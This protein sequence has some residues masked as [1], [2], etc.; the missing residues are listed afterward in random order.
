MGKEG[1][2]NTDSMIT[3]K[4]SRID[5]AIG[6]AID[7]LFALTP[8]GWFGSDNTGTSSTIVSA[9]TNKLEVDDE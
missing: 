9:D 5:R 6:G 7:V 1:V 3:G 8:L 2:M 4:E